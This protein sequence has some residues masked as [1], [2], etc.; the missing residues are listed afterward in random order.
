ML[1]EWQKILIHERNEFIIMNMNTKAIILFQN[2]QNNK[3]VIKAFFLDLKYVCI[4]IVIA[5]LYN[6]KEKKHAIYLN[7]FIIRY[8]IKKAIYM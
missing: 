3:T 7:A 8:D 6:F 1:S 4:K 5:N 2:S